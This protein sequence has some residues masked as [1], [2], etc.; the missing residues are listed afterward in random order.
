MKEKT[1]QLKAQLPVDVATFLLNEKRTVISEIEARQNLSIILIPNLHMQTP[2]Y[3]VQ[4]IRIDEIPPQEK[5][6]YEQVA[7]TEEVT[8]AKAEK[9]VVKR[10]EPAVKMVSQPTAPPP[11]TETATSPTPPA[12]PISPPQP[13]FL[14]RLL[15]AIFTASEE[16][17]KEGKKEKEPPRRTKAQDK[18]GRG[19]QSQ[20]RGSRRR[21]RGGDRDSQ[22]SKQRQAEQSEKA[23]GQSGGKEAAGG[24]QDSSSRQADADSSER[25]TR[26]GKRGGRRRG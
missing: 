19:G 10:E 26:R 18:R 9:Q 25:G 7:E 12:S 3:E 16:T 5:P 22:E 14:R 11:A 24:T 8:E 4:R 15:G 13:G 21:G 1:G 6:S 2:H 23:K 20:A 17:E